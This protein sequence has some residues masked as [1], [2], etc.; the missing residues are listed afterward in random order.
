[1]E[2]LLQSSG[3]VIN[4]SPVEAKTSPSEAIEGQTTLTPNNELSNLMINDAGE[5]KYIGMMEHSERLEHCT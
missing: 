5:Q 2:A 1:M 4:P 3:I